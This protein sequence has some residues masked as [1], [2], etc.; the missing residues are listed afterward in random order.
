MRKWAIQ[1]PV[2]ICCLEEEEDAISSLTISQELPADEGAGSELL[3]KAAAQLQEYFAGTRRVFDLP[4]SAKG[5]AFEMAVWQALRE[6]PY[7]QTRTYGQIASLIGHPGAARAVGR[8]CSR[9]PLLIVVP[10]H[11]VLGAGGKLTG[12]TAGL[13]VK[14]ALLAAED[15]FSE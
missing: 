5:T 14:R 2:G 7:G 12:F 15:V 11:R 10:C 4:I 8:A 13:E 9:N 3:F 6:I 1:A